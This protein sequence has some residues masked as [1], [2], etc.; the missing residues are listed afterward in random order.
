MA[1]GF[2]YLQDGR[3]CALRWRY[4]DRLVTLIIMQLEAM[5]NTEEFASWLR[6]QIPSDDDVVHLGHGPW[7]RRSD[8]QLIRRVLDIRELSPA[9]QELFARAAKNAVQF[10]KEDLDKQA[11]SKLVAMLA[12]V[13]TGQ[14]PGELNDC[15]SLKPPS[16]GKVGPHWNSDQ[17]VQ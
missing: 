15:R 1:S 4:Y 3:A 5:P 8:G 2:I 6:R 14:P 12:A 13:E 16:G 11:I 7:R 10:A 17:N 9:C